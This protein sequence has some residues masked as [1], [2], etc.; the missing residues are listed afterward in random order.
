MNKAIKVQEQRQLADFC[1]SILPYTEYVADQWHAGNHFLPSL[2][3]LTNETLTQRT[4]SEPGQL[5]AKQNKT[6]C[7]CSVGVAMSH[8]QDFE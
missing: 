1:S 6:S 8:W 4:T 5:V 7:V 3:L 2:L